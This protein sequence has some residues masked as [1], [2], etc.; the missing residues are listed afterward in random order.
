MSAAAA[1]ARGAG[2]R[3]SAGE[4]AAPF[5]DRFCSPYFA[6]ADLHAAGWWRSPCAVDGAAAFLL[7]LF[8]LGSIAW[9]HVSWARARRRR[10]RRGGAAALS[11][12]AQAAAAAADGDEQLLQAPLL[13]A[14]DA[15]ERGSTAASAAPPTTTV[16][17]PAAQSTAAQAAS[18]T[19]I[20][21]TAVGLCVSLCALHASHGLACLLLGLPPSQALYHLSGLLAWLLGGAACLRAARRHAAATAAAASVAAGRGQEAEDLDEEEQEEEEEQR[22][23]AGG[24]GGGGGA[25]G[26]GGH[27]SRGSS[28][29]SSSSMSEA[30][31][32]L[33]DLRPLVAAAFLVYLCEAAESLS[34]YGRLASVAARAAR[35]AREPAALLA[36]AALRSV[37]LGAMVAPAVPLQQPPPPFSSSSSDA[38][39]T[40]STT[41]TITDPYPAAYVKVHV[42]SSVLAALLSA[43]VAWCRRKQRQDETE[44]QRKRR[45]ARAKRRAL[46]S[47]FNAAK[48][49]PGCPLPQ[50][51]VREEKQYTWPQLFVA[52]AAYAWPDDTAL[53]ARVLVCGV[54]LLLVRLLNLAVPLFYKRLVDALARASSSTLA[55]V[56]GGGGAAAAAEGAPLFAPTSAANPTPPPSPDA[57]TPTTFSS[58]FAPWELL[59]LVALFFQGGAGGG[60]V[61][62]LNNARSYVFIPVGQAAGRR[63]ALACMDHVLEE[64]DLAWHLSRRTG[65]VTRVID[66]GTGAVQNLLSTVVFSLGPQMV[67]VFAASFLLAGAL[68]PA[69]AAVAFATVALY[70]PMTVAVTEWRSSFRRDLNARDNARGAC[71]TDALL[72]WE[73][74]KIMSA[75]KRELRRYAD[76]TDSYI[77][78]ERAFLASLNALNVAQSTLMFSGVATGLALCTAGVARGL[79]TVG[80]VTLFLAL[81]AQ[82]SAPLNFF[83]TYFRMIAQYMVD[84]QSLF[85]LLDQK[86]AVR[87]REGA[88]DLA[89]PPAA[90]AGT[91]RDL[92]PRVGVE[93]VGVTFGYPAGVAAAGGGGTGPGG[94]P[95]GGGGG[96]GGAGGRGGGGGGAA[97]GGGGGR[98]APGG[99]GSAHGGR[100][101]A[102][103]GRGHG[104]HGHGPPPPSS[105]SLSAPAPPVFIPPRAV[106]RDV[107]FAIPPGGT[108]AL[109]GATGS[110]KTTATRLLFRFFDPWSGAILINGQDIASV[111]QRSLRRA[112]GIVSQ[113]I[114]LFNDTLRYNIRYARP[115]ATDSEVEAAAKAAQIHEAISGRFPQG[116]DT[117]V[118]ER[119]LKL[120]G[121]EKQRVAIARAF[122]KRPPILVFGE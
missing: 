117:V 65:E 88:A 120:S 16:K 87:D 109:V 98:G 41:T 80:D 18:I 63:A 7:I 46:R 21:A 60:I 76:A 28:G 37:G 94:G 97:H 77:S 96:G 31:P 121:G 57:P 92:L 54:L 6:A 1:L 114:V 72:G 116:Y 44:A 113:D 70:V 5:V 35:M 59:Y 119:G 58:L 75:E 106:L 105:S 89:L 17:D 103:G 104:A 25:A 52:A 24:G 3:G 8:A 42:W 64:L 68:Q 74:V 115:E 85:Q 118:G 107:S 34:I 67:D 13:A 29:S 47:A 27:R 49:P 2:G 40:P 79:L 122:L 101:G 90:P 43:C 53:R 111:T 83:G 84:T 93:F 23:Q 45:A 66:R 69:V 15:A 10:P 62:F 19:G 26:G 108:C 14:A 81:L 73:T 38:A 22:R 48:L 91:P 11:S 12:S 51:L 102:H 33:P 86:G 4:D 56:G 20:E 82:L 100:G 112:I 30:G 39:T 99:G 71:V 32:L 61:G 36:A 78:S 110:G 50:E 55:E 95:G 9:A